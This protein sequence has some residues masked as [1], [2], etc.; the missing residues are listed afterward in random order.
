MSSTDF[1]KKAKTKMSIKLQKKKVFRETEPLVAIFMWGINYTHN[2]LKQIPMP[3]LLMP[4]EF[5]SY[6]KVK[7]D[8]QNFNKAILPS[9]YKV[10]EYC[11]VVFKNIRERFNISEESYLRSLTHDGMEALDDTNS[12]SNARF[13][14]SHDKR[15]VVKT[16]TSE[17]VE[18]LHNILQ[19]Y[20]KHIV[21]TKGNT[22]LPHLLGLFRLTVENKENY[23]LVMR[24][25]FSNKFK[26]HFKYDIKGSTVDREASLKEKEKS[27]PTFKDN[28]LLNEARQIHIGPESKQAFME[29]LTRDVAFLTALKIMDY[30]LLIGI[31]DEKLCLTKGANL[32]SDSGGAS[33]GEGQG[34]PST[35]NKFRSHSNASET[36]RGAVSGG[37]RT[38][39]DQEE[40]FSPGEECEDH[41]EDGQL[42]SS[43][44][45]PPGSPFTSN[46]RVGIF[47]IPSAA[48]NK[49][50][51]YFMA[52]IDILT[53]YG[54]KKRSANVAKTVKYGDQEISTVKPEQYSKRFLEFVNRIV[55]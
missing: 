12:K 28:D 23:V 2:E 27:H 31:H 44:P 1:K 20:H 48:E 8:N 43:C 38:D 33:E 15:Y 4:D 19:D 45:T 50:E 25:V 39:S 36:D 51:I 29:K 6:I 11:P 35:Q 7:I 3:E 5:K 18:G 22:L 40:N 24:S 30:S 55:S 13:Y 9:H 32:T 47:G 52:L 37:D 14:R 54:L 17:D 41:D 26:V 53:Q 21:E 10:K 42:N 34:S 16:V 49:K 46:S